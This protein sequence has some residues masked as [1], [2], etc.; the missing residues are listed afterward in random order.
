MNTI[1]QNRIEEAAKKYCR[2][3]NYILPDDTELSLEALTAI[4]AYIEAAKSILQNQ[5]ISVEEALPPRTYFLDGKES[6]KSIYV[7]V[8]YKNGAVTSAWYCYCTKVWYFAI[9]R[10]GDNSIHSEI[11]HWMEIP[12][13]KGGEE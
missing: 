9:G 5:W 7:L 4:D 12:S 8:R 1:L 13:L 11:T 3:K 2:D 6:D 10:K